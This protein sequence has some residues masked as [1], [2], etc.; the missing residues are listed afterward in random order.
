[1]VLRR[2]DPCRL[3]FNYLEITTI[4]NFNFQMLLQKTFPLSE[5]DGVN[6]ICQGNLYIQFIDSLNFHFR[7]IIINIGIL[8]NLYELFSKISKN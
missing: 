8:S 2:R 7:I 5:P 6:F 4:R 3:Y 1:M